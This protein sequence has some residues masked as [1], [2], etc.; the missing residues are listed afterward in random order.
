MLGVVRFRVTPHDAR[1]RVLVAI[2]SHRQ[3]AAAERRPDE[4][5]E[6]SMISPALFAI[7]RMACDERGPDD[8]GNRHRGFTTK[9][10]IGGPTQWLIRDTRHTLAN[11]TTAST[12]NGTPRS[13]PSA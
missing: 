1:T 10:V 13:S 4:E 12:L 6:A 11:S 3:P 2:S 8:D 7:P 9:W 5:K